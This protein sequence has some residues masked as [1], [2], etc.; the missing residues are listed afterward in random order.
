MPSDLTP[1]LLFW[2]LRHDT[3][4]Y[5]CEL[6]RDGDAFVLLIRA[7]GAAVRTLQVPD[8]RSATDVADLWKAEHRARGMVPA[9]RWP[10]PES[11]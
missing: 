10:D 2:R 11:E 3:G 9:H 4:L 5:T 7:S 6:C 1:F 8:V